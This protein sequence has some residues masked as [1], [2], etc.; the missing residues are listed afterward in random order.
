MFKKISIKARLTAAFLTVITLFGLG[1]WTAL[2]GVLVSSDHFDSFFAENYVRQTAYQNMFSEGLLSGIALRNLVLNP[3]LK[4]PYSVTPKAI[5]RFDAAYQNA[6]K[7]A[8]ADPEILEQLKQI[9]NFWQKSRAAKLKALELMKANKVDDAKQLLVTEEHPN[10]RKVRIAVQ[11]LAMAEET[12]AKQLRAALLQDKD[13]TIRN[14]TI[15]SLLALLLGGAV[16]LLIVGNI[17]NAFQR[18]IDSLN[19][20]ASGGGDLTQR[21]DDSGRDEVAAMGRAF[22]QFV[23]KIQNLI[24]QI[25]DT[26]NQLT[27]SAGNMTEHSTETK[28]SMNQQ[29]SK[30]EQVATAMNEMTATVQEVARHAAEASNAAQAADSEAVAGSQIVKQ[31]VHAIN[32]LATEV[33]ESAGTIASLEQSTEQIGTVLDVIRGIAEQTNLLALNAAIEAARAG[34]HGRGF[35]VVADEVRTLAS[36]TQQSTQE[37]HSMIEKLQEGSKSAVQAMDHSQEK[38][39]RVVEEANRA[40][41]ALN[42]ITEAVSRIAD[43]NTQ[44]AT[45]A[46]EQSAVSEDINQNVVSISTLAQQA[47]AS[48]EHTASLSQDLEHVADAL[49]QSISVFKV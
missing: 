37:I 10:W 3:T 1:T 36:R 14:T 6:V 24:R 12:R 4:K 38:T 34:E 49:Q 26:G 46:E 40:G 13:A 18:I 48:A 32:D 45:A 17:R 15:L 21:L 2:R 16:A 39:A 35:A 33:R 7:L 19:D 11:K 41:D 30:V 23:G 20:I 9:D 42:T 27:Q 29:E 5:A 44:I 22:N 25:A 43:M 28:Y 8:K 47:A 31:V